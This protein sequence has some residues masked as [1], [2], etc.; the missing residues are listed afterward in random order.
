MGDL[1]PELARLIGDRVARDNPSARIVG[2]DLRE[3]LGGAGGR[4][5][6]S[7]MYAR[8]HLDGDPD[9]VLIVATLLGRA[10]TDP[11]TRV[12]VLLNPPHGAFVLDGFGALMDQDPRPCARVASAS[13]FWS[14]TVGALAEGFPGVSDQPDLVTIEPGPDDAIGVSITVN[15]SVGTGT[16]VDVLAYAVVDG[17]VLDSGTFA[18]HA[19]TSIVTPITLTLSFAGIAGGPGA[20][21]PVNVG[22]KVLNYGPTEAYIS[23]GVNAHLACLADGSGYTLFHVPPT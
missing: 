22:Y 1:Y 16:E 23:V 5:D 18:S 11:G 20:R 6:D 12:A 4:V 14:D 8:V 7:A 15:V 17:V 9:D 13:Y 19:Q 21:R 2:G 10:P 3:V